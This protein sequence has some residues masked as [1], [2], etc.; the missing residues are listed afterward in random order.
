MNFL[1]HHQCFKNKKATEFAIKE[2]KKYNPD[3]PYVLW[4]DAGENYG[5][6]VS[7][8]DVD[9][10]YSNKNVGYRY[11]NKDKAFELL[12]R[13]RKSCELHSDLPYVMWMEDDV[14]VR[15][16]VK[17]PVGI[18]F[19]A[20]PDIGNKFYGETLTYLTQK[21]NVSPNFDYYCTAGGTIMSSDVF[22]NNFN[23]LEKFLEE[24]Y[25]YIIKNIWTEL[26]HHDIII[27][28]CH[29]IC[30]KRYS[31]NPYHTEL[32]KNPDWKNSQ[33]TIVHGYKEHY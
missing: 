8:Y 14:L 27:M 5:D 23:I 33:F 10:F 7:L 12:N 24:D 18:D 16:Q 4:S 9:Y 20:G 17:V 31:I 1:V 3:I 28:I 13:V 6:F 2:F 21:Y 30:N 32:T 19:C 29:L 15:S 26:A 22:T 25:D 11:Y